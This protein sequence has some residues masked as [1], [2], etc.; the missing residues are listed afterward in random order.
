MTAPGGV[1][2]LLPD[3]QRLTGLSPEQIRLLKA[4]G[5]EPTLLDPA[6]TRV[7]PLLDRLVAAGLLTVT[8][9]SG[10]VDLYS[11]LPFAPP[12]PRTTPEA[13]R[14]PI[15]LSKFAVIHRIA[16]R[17][18]AE[19]P[20]S[21]CDIE[22]HDGR[23][24]AAIAGLS[25]TGE[26]SSDALSRLADDL[27]WAGFVTDPRSEHD[28]F[29]TRSWGPHELWFHRRST[30]GVRT[31]DWGRFG[32]TKWA[33]GTFPPLPARKTAYATDPIALPS[34][35][36]DSLRVAG[37]SLTAAIEDRTSCRDFAAQ[38][39]PT[40]EQLGEFLFR[41]ARNRTL[42]LIGDEEF[43]SKPFPSGGGLYEMEVYPVV[44]QVH[45]LA[46]GMYHYDAFDHALRPVAA[47]DRPAISRLLTPSS[48]TLADG[49]LP[50]ILFVFAARVGRVMWTYEQ[51]PYAVMLKHVGV[52]TQTMS[53]VATDMGLGSVAQGYCDTAAFAELAGVDEMAECAMG[54]LVLGSPRR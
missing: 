6:D 28:D 22:I 17:C 41:T 45:G 52:L 25:D 27:G 5:R 18:V 20:M 8:V 37:D 46:A 35:D 42:R 49:Q 24:L 1:A 9:R 44:R 33:A 40:V 12:P 14:L 23:V 19:H 16:D 48:L 39:P 50:Q 29:A 53:L 4:L 32:P 2:V 54:S 31:R 26:L 10:G 7:S 30:F 38:S 15:T 51:I 34:P 21:W 11:L 13:G 47:I 43:P 36:L 3:K